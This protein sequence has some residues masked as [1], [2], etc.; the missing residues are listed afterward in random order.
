MKYIIISAIAIL[1]LTYLFIRSNQDLSD[2]GLNIALS[3][4]D[5]KTSYSKEFEEYWYA[6]NAELSGYD[7]KQARYGEMRSGTATLV[8]VTE[9]FSKN[10]QVKLD[11]PTKAGRD[12]V[13]VLKLNASRNFQTGIYP[14]SMMTSVF[15][16]VNDKELVHAL[17]LTLTGQEWCGHVF[18]QLNKDGNSYN[19][20]SFSYFESEGDKNISISKSVL[21]DEIFNIIR[22]NPDLLTVGDIEVI[23]NFTVLRFL[24]E[25]TKA[26]KATATK[27]STAWKGKTVNTYTLD[28]PHNERQVVIYYSPKFP[29][30]V[31]GWED[32]YSSGGEKMTTTALRK[33]TIKLDYWNKNANEYQNLYKNL[34]K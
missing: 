10:K 16:P 34:Y 3:S 28:Y 14:Y 7:L 25:E 1:G 12:N 9:P 29:Y 13:S 18:Q 8:F 11:N 17:K 26:Y 6:G 5:I 24:H 31:E 15:S 27:S 32:T 19:I 21:E 2:S 20:A 30:L 23:P 22:M 4:G 33:N